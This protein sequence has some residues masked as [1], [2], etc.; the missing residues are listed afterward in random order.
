[1]NIIKVSSQH[2]KY[3]LAYRFMTDNL[4]DIFEFFIFYSVLK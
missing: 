3:D 1:M 2:G 4:H